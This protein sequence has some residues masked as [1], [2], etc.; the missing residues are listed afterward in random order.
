MQ[1][2]EDLRRTGENVGLHLALQAAQIVHATARSGGCARRR[3]C[4]SSASR[5]FQRRDR[6]IAF[7]DG[8]DLAETARRRFIKRPHRIHHRC[9]VGVDQQGL[10]VAVAG[11]VELLNA[12]HR[13]VAKIFVGVKA[14]IAA[15][16]VDVV[17]VQQDQ[18]IGAS[19]QLRQKR[20]LR[21]LGAFEFGIAGNVFQHQAAAENILHLLDAFAHVPKALFGE[22]AGASDRAVARRPHRSSTGDRRSTLARWC[23][24]APSGD[25]GIRD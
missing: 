13:D 15:A 9:I 16:D 18:A 14:M 19:G 25:A 21:H 1:V 20:P 8:G 17:D 6:C 3:A 12:F 11:E 10:L 2:G 7:D 5:V 23:A 22:A 4:S 24:P